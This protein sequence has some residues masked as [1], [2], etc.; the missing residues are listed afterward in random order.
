VPSYRSEKNFQDLAISC[1]VLPAVTPIRR[2]SASNRLYGNVFDKVRGRRLYFDAPT[3]DKA[4]QN[5]Y[6][7]AYG[8]CAVSIASPE[9]ATPPSSLQLTKQSVEIV[10]AVKF[11]FELADFTAAFYVNLCS[12]VTGKIG[13]DI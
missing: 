4:V 7:S 2:I 3:T 13:R 8:R 6:L 1:R 10:I 12:K 5:R 11:D 9:Q